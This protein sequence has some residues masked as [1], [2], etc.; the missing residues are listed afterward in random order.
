YGPKQLAELDAAL[1]ELALMLQHT[2]SYDRFLRHLVEGVEASHPKAGDDLHREKS[3]STPAII[4]GPVLPERTKLEE[5]AGEVSALYAELE[6]GLFRCSLRKALAID[7]V[8]G[9]GGLVTSSCVEDAFFVAQ[10]WLVVVL[11]KSVDLS[12]C[13]ED[14]FFVAQQLQPQ[15]YQSGEFL[16]ALAGQVRASLGTLPGLGGTAGGLDVALRQLGQIDFSDLGNLGAQFQ[17]NL[18][19]LQGIGQNIAS[20]LT[21]LGTSALTNIPLRGGGTGGGGG[22]PGAAGQGA[23]GAAAAAAGGAGAGGVAGAVTGGRGACLVYLN[24][25]EACGQCAARLGAELVREVPETFQEGRG[26]QLLLACLGELSGAADAFDQ[27]SQRS[28]RHPCNTDLVTT[29]PRARAQ[30][31]YKLTEAQYA[32][33]EASDPWALELA[34]GL[35]SLLRP[36]EPPTGLSAAAFARLLA[37]ACECAAQRVEAAARRKRFSQL[38]G[39][40]LDKDVRALAAA[41]AERGGPALRAP[42][43]RL[44]Q[45]ALLLSLDDVVDAADFWHG[46]GALRQHLAAGE[47]KEV[48]ALREDFAPESVAELEL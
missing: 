11:Y 21:S 23:G 46:G 44:Q 22:G 31:S 24:D 29:Q 34:T 27:R 37:L 15:L 20:D 12:S 16:E 19:G 30:V 36:Y 17:D 3:P 1:D 40:Q 41:A 47:V 32:V 14:A 6:A 45:I 2:E 7:E 28:L 42:F 13:V 18:Q 43:A 35:L 9:H 48:L 33:N 8:H 25:L 5:A 4:D 26:A 10:P 38:G 39:L